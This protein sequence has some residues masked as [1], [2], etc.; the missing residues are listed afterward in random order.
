MP[1]RG[2][3]LGEGGVGLPDVPPVPY[4]EPRCMAADH[5]QVRAG[6]AMRGRAASV[7]LL[8]LAACLWVVGYAQMVP[9]ARAVPG[10]MQGAQDRA[11]ASGTGFPQ[12]A[13]PEQ[14]H[15]STGEFF[16]VF[17]FVFAFA[18]DQHI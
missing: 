4:P 16:G 3:E 6:G 18:P 17:F 12:A 10:R 2:G 7:G 9:P 13:E 1:W 15:A 14:D 8:C 5:G 11:P